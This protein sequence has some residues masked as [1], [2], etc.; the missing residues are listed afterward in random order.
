MHVWPC[1]TSGWLK[2][3][4]DFQEQDAA[5][6]REV[7]DKQNQCH[8]CQCWHE[9]PGFWGWREP[10]CPQQGPSRAHCSRSSRWHV[11]CLCWLL[12]DPPF[13]LPACGLGSIM[14]YCFSSQSSF[15]VLIQFPNCYAPKSAEAGALAAAALGNCL[16]AICQAV[17]VIK[18]G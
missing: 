14:L 15:L 6:S 9:A 12:K 8:I 5:L 2:R 1:E 16:S 4:T 3:E 17:F 13:P 18:G 10:C 7:W 11:V